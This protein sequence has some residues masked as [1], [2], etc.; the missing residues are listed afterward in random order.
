MVAPP[1]HQADVAPCMGC[2]AEDMESRMWLDR[3]V[4]DDTQIHHHHF[5]GEATHEQVLG[6]QDRTGDSRLLGHQVWEVQEHT[7]QENLVGSQL[8]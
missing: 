3:S 5:G 2:M 1:G 6:L 8:G 7:V 4:G